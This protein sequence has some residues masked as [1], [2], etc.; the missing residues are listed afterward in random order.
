MQLQVPIKCY[1]CRVLYLV[2]CVSFLALHSNNL[3]HSS[4][5]YS[6]LHNDLLH[7][8]HPPVHPRN[9]FLLVTLKPLKPLC[10]LLPLPLF[11]RRL[12][13]LFCHDLG[14]TSLELAMRDFQLSILVDYALPFVKQ[15]VALGCWA[16]RTGWLVHHAN[17]LSRRKSEEKDVIAR[18]H[19]Q[20]QSLG[21]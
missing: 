17:M 20:G 16:T 11:A 10:Q 8:R 6:N 7:F 19:G 3:P 18:V 1:R 13:A 12:P 15:A 2:F 14:V 21:P 5:P 4:H 9:F